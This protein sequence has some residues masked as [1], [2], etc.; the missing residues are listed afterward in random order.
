MKQLH[1]GARPL[2]MNQLCPVVAVRQSSFFLSIEDFENLLRC[3]SPSLRTLEY[4]QQQYSFRWLKKCCSLRHF[5]FE[6]SVIL[7]FNIDASPNS[8]LVYFIHYHI[9]H[10]L[11]KEIKSRNQIISENLNSQRASK[12]FYQR[13]LKRLPNWRL[14]GN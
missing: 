3:R 9:M 10:N 13:A 2:R 7:I 11:S 12:S 5:L 1:F 6:R 8:I 14:T 4:E